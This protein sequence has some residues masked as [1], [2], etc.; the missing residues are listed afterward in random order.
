LTNG[1]LAK[2]FQRQLNIVDNFAMVTGP[3]S[4]RFGA[5]YRRLS[6]ISGVQEY[7]LTVGFNTQSSV[8]S[9][10]AS[11]ASIT[12]NKGRLYP[13]FTNFSAYAQDT[14]RVG[15]RLTAT[16]GLRWELNPPP[17]EANGDDPFTV[18]GLDNPATMT[19]APQGTPF[20]ETTCVEFRAASG[21]SLPV[22]R[23][24]GRE[25]ALRGG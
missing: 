13:R 3:H 6:P 4:L 23:I 22:V 18:R 25:M 2:N 12:G 16:Y 10:T 15:R 19:L 24:A 9:G 21:R 1:P 5:D 17:S 20:F 7:N 14:W 8:L 11:A